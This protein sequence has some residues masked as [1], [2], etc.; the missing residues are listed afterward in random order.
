MTFIFSH[1]QSSAEVYIPQTLQQEELGDNLTLKS[2]FCC[3]CSKTNV[4]Y[5]VMRLRRIIKR[6]R[7]RRPNNKI[8]GEKSIP[9]TG[10]IFSPIF[11]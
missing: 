7:K 10:G 2:I 8:N 6:L 1:L 4:A 5:I 3:I 9:E 11:L